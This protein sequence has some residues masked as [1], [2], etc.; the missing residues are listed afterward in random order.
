MTV[1]T[2]RFFCDDDGW[3]IVAVSVPFSQWIG[4]REKLQENPMILMGNSMVS[5]EDFPV[6]TNPLIQLPHRKG[7]EGPW[8][9]LPW[10]TSETRNGADLD[11]VPPVV[12]GAKRRDCDYHMGVSSI[13][14]GPHCIEWLIYVNIILMVILNSIRTIL[15][16]VI[17]DNIWWLVTIDIDSNHDN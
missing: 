17:I 16:T 12:W 11:S 3:L 4:L 1:M 10:R 6:K 15:W 9:L 13:F 14:R 2:H 8:F 5:G 7:L